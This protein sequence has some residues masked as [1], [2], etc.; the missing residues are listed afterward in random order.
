MIMSQET[1]AFGI[2]GLAFG[3]VLL[4]LFWLF[5]AKPLSEKLLKFGK[6]KWAMRLRMNQAKKAGCSNCK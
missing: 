4:K 1:I 2:V 5:L 6:V 3:S